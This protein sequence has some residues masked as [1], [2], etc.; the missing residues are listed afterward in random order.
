MLFFLSTYP[1]WFGVTNGEGS[2]MHPKRL[3]TRH[4]SCPREFSRRALPIC[5]WSDTLVA[6]ESVNRFA[7]GRNGAV[8]LVFNRCS[9]FLLFGVFIVAG[10]ATDSHQPAHAGFVVIPS[11][12]QFHSSDFF[13]ASLPPIAS[14]TLSAFAS[15]N[16]ASVRS[17]RAA[18][19]P[20]KT[21]FCS[22]EQQF[23]RVFSPSLVN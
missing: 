19:F 9:P 16:E 7:Q 22:V 15:T 18:L 2:R 3:R 4:S 10:P 5:R 14:L 6:N 17:N 8:T 20:A 13:P 21:I 11:S 12:L 23:S 1:R